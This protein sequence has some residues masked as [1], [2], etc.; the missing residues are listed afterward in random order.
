MD[1]LGNVE[2]VADDSKHDAV[3]YDHRETRKPNP[4]I[5]GN[6]AFSLELSGDPAP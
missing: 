2:P 6:D 1:T 3:E 5:L 4:E